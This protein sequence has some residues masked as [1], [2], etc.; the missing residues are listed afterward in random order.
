V[1]AEEEDIDL[2]P[3]DEERGAKVATEK[4]GNVSF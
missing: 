4:S 1:T 3:V 2:Q